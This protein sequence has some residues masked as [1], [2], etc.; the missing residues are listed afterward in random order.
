M[1]ICCAFAL[2]SS[3]GSSH[4]RQFNCIQRAHQN[5]LEQLPIWFA[6]QAALAS[7]HPMTAGVLGFVW[8]TGAWSSH[9]EAHSSDACCETDASALAGGC[10]VRCANAAPVRDLCMPRH[11]SA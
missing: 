3:V 2:L 8:M 9:A 7:V 1:L 6:A 5:T 11:A 10:E 4:R